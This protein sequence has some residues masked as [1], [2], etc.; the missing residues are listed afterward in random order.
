MR[1]GNGNN[2]NGNGWEAWGKHVLSTLET[3][4]GTIKE[5]NKQQQ[6]QN[7]TL[8][9]NTITVEEH[10]KYSINLE[11]KLNALEKHIT[12]VEVD[13]QPIKK[14]VTKVNA[15]TKAVIIGAG[16]IGTIVGLVIKFFGGEG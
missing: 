14:H 3:L 6:Q 11:R 8:L 16:A 5:I 15:I 9:R 10:K 7:E 13:M 4:S 12:S 2:G 1:N